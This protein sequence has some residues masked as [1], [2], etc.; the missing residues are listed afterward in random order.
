MSIQFV[1]NNRNDDRNDG[2][3]TVTYLDSFTPKI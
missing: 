2:R 1:K 3:S